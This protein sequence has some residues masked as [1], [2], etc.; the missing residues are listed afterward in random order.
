MAYVLKKSLEK[1]KKL[2]LYAPG[3]ICH[4][5]RDKREKHQHYSCNDALKCGGYC[6]ECPLELQALQEC[7]V[8]EAALY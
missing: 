5:C 3:G 4:I 2:E 6:E 1:D 8:K 7:E